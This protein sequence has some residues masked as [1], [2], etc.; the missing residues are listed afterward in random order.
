MN[1]KMEELSENEA[2]MK[3]FSG[4]NTAVTNTVIL[5]FD[6]LMLFAS[7]MLFVNGGGWI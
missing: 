7:G 4:R 5:F 6:V 3:C 2:K 1:E